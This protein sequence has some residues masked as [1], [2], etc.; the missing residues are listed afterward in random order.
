MSIVTFEDE[1]LLKIET[2]KSGQ[3]PAFLKT[4]F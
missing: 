4:E 3:M 2:K 1:D